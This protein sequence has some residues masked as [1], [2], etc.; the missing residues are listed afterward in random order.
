MQYW[1][2]FIEAL[3]F[4]ST[5]VFLYATGLTDDRKLTIFYTIGCFLLGGHLLLMGAYAGGLTTTLSGIRNIAAMKDKTGKVKRAFMFVFIGIFIY[6]C[7][8]FTMW[9]DLLVPLASVVMSVGFIYFKGNK[10]TLCMMLSCSLWLLYGLMIQSNAIIFLEVTSIMMASYRMLKQNNL[11]P[12]FNLKL[13][14][15]KVSI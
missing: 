15:R 4:A 13:K 8:N 1:D 5:A 6:Y 14:R 7:F 3:G 11:M 12:K 10:L 2:L 9:Y